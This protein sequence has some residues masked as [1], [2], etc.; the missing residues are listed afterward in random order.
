M[1]HEEEES[2]YGQIN[3]DMNKAENISSKNIKYV[4]KCQCILDSH[5]TSN[6]NIFIFAGTIDNHKFSDSL[7]KYL[8]LSI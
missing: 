7:Y 1:P 6:N 2:L 8:D 5:R 3:S 4:W